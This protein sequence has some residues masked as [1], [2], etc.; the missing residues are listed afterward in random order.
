MKVAKATEKID[1][2]TPAMVLISANMKISYKK[3]STIKC[4]AVM[5]A[6][7]RINNAKG[8][9]KML[10]TSTKISIGFTPIGT[11]GAVSI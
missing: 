9:V 8:F 7:S 11:P 3:L 1:I 2:P 4:P 10:K 5:L 6:K